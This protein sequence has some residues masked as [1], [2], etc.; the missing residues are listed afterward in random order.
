[1]AAVLSAL[2]LWGCGQRPEAEPPATVAAAVSLR[3]VMPALVE[4][5]A[6]RGGGEVAVTFGASGDIRRQVEGGAPLDMIILAAAA[7]VEALVA[8][9]LAH[10]PATIAT[11][12]IVLVG[13]RG[14]PPLTFATID[15]LPAGEVLAVGEP[16]SVPVG[17][18]ARAY[19][20][21]LG[22]WRAVSGRV[23]FG[24]NVGAVLS[25][26]RR[27]EAAAAIVYRTDAASGAEVELLDVAA[28]EAAP[29]PQVV[30]ALTRAGSGSARALA[31]LEFLRAREGQEILRAHG[32]GPPG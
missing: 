32:F 14:G 30:A 26:A 8:R 25:Y 12:Q 3:I 7:P 1:M 20:E 21:R 15:R 27:G 16:S 6:E 19:L 11:N 31:F 23:V 10:G 13:P 5:F 29:R 4:A 18:H 2:F 22:K 24:G 9:G 17:E 28:G